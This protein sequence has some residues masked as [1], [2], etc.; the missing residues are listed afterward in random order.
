MGFGEFRA[1]AGATLPR[2]DEEGEELLLRAM[3]F[4]HELGSLIYFRKPG[5]SDI[6]ILDPHWLTQV[7]VR[8]Y[9]LLRVQNNVQ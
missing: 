4:L 5:L 7:M 1:M 6:V 3:E 9:F 8:R 2:L